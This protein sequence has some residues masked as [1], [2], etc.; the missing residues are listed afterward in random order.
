MEQGGE[1][2]DESIGKAAM[3]IYELLH[4]VSTRMLWDAAFRYAGTFRK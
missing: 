3:R 2:T 4:K 1:E